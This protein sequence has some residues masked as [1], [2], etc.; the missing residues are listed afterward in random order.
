MEKSLKPN[1]ILILNHI[2]DIHIL[3]SLIKNKPLKPGSYR[4]RK[5]T[6]PEKPKNFNGEKHA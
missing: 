3:K 6:A 4:G 5:N 1:T 2:P